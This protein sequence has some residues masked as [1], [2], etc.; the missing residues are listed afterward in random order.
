MFGADNDA[1]VSLVDGGATYGITVSELCSQI[2]DG[3]GDR[4]KFALRDL[5]R[6][7]GHWGPLAFQ[8]SRSGYPQESATR[9]ADA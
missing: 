8:P 9:P 2:E 4:T 5:D 1:V 3:A 7:K 6:A